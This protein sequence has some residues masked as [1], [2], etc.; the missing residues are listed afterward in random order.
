MVRPAKQI[1]DRLGSA[2]LARAL[3]DLL[4]Q[5]RLVRLATHCGLKY[6]GMRTQTQRRERLLGDLVGEAERNDTARRAILHSLHK[7]TAQAGKDWEALEP[8]KKLERLRDSGFLRSGGNLGLHVFLLASSG[9]DADLEWTA[10]T[11]ALEHLLRLGSDGTKVALEPSAA[12]LRDA[13]RLR[14]KLAA[15]EKKVR[16]ADNQLVKSRELQRTLKRDLIQR[17]G[18]LAESRMLVERLR[19]ELLAAQAAAQAASAKNGS[20]PAPEREI[21][22]LAQAVRK[23]ESAQRKLVN[24]MAV[25]REPPPAPLA[26]RA[27]RDLTAWKEA[28]ELLKGGFERQRRELRK[29][30]GAQSRR[31]DEL[32]TELHE[33]DDSAGRR[34]VRRSRVKGAGARVGV[35]IDVQNVYYGARRLKGKLDFDAL[36]EAAV[37]DRRLIQ[38]TA[39]VVES[40]EIDQS[41]FIA[42][43]EQR[44]IKV[45]RKALKV[46]A[47]GS[48]KGDWDME[49]ALDALDAAPS[50]DVVVLVSGDGDFTSLV[51]R[52]K[53][54]GPRVEVLGFPRHVAKSLAQAADDY[55]PLDRKFM[56]YVRAPKL[57][58]AEPDPVATESTKAISPAE[59]TRR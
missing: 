58:P 1:F 38:A 26:P 32:R 28:T 53:A 20:T 18:E 56:I 3:D 22:E 7:E 47:D 12:G 36:L 2:G 42:R 14:R 48:M 23:L 19:G 35:F 15:L 24:R 29:E 30:L 9:D 4:D 8:A 44:G 55:R 41:Q 16:Y 25:R 6:R 43:L 49:L 40:E 11:S 57:A 54:M 52:I 50:L 45:Q 51:K 31:L 21:G 37:L 39:Y 17:K 5:E 33:R 34:G 59:E 46:R 10:G 13:T 27:D